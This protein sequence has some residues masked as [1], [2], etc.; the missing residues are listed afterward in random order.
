MKR[1]L[2]NL[3]IWAFDIGP[4]VILLGGSPYETISSRVWKR[5]EKGDLWAIV[6]AAYINTIFL[7]SEH[8]KKSRIP[9]EIITNAPNWWRI[10]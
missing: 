1:Y 2:L 10:D 3:A 9:D 5:V 4:N 7:D 6:V 8:C